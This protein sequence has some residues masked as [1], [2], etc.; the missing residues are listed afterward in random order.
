[1][2]QWSVRD[3][4]TAAIALAGLMSCGEG[5]PDRPIAYRGEYHYNAESAY[6]V[7]AGVEAKICVQG[8]DMAPAI[9]PEFSS[10]GGISEVVVRGILSK[11]GKYGHSGVCT[12]QLTNSELLGVGERRERE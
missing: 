10:S 5:P 4:I 7:Q 3:K 6:L 9:Q 12:Y 8:A 1:M 2:L 11:P